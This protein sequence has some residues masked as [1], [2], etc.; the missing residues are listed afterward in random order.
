MKQNSDRLELNVD[1]IEQH[2]KSAVDALTPDVLGR[3]DLT[4]GQEP[5]MQRLDVK[6]HEPGTQRLDVKMHEP[7]AGADET[8]F[9]GQWTGGNHR[10]NRGWMRRFALAAAAC[11]CV[12]FVGG[13]MIQ[14][15]DRKV[16]SVIGIDVNPSVELSINRKHRVL[17]TRALNTD[18]VEIMTDMDLKGVELNVA[19]N[20][21]IGSMVTHGYLD[22]LDNAIL[23]TVS[24]DSVAKATE[25]R[26]SVVDDIER[27]LKENQVEAVV[28]DQQV[29]EKDE[30]K[31]LADRY[32]ISYGKAYFLKELIEQNEGLTMDDMKELSN[33]T[34]EEI[35]K[36]ITEDSFALGGLASKVER[37]G[38]TA[39]TKTAAPEAGS[40]AD[41]TEGA[42]TAGGETSEAVETSGA[43]GTVE[44]GDA[45]KTG[46]TSEAADTSKAADTSEAATPSESAETSAASESPN[47]ED[48]EG[49]PDEVE[50]GLVEIDYVDYEDDTVYVYFVTRVKWKN[51]TVSVRDEDG[52]SYAAKVEDTSSDECTIAVSG[53]EGGRS[54]AFVLGGLIPKES[55]K[56]T[57][58]TGYF[59]KPE[60]AWNADEPE[61]EEMEESED[62]REE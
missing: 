60:I 36:K 55:K 1:E 54:Y 11:I 20:A 40:E 62:D 17:G 56:A 42:E 23:V 39:E 57:T 7:G 22:E 51:P 24:N 15:R 47:Q 41:G 33:M 5:E 27:T 13:G 9:P 31:E 28:Y 46:E 32:G 49:F 44:A 2:L 8:D 10:Q 6:T 43:E 18:A 3:I 4:R 50:P 12:A 29:V 48:P 61:T 38:E 19:V 59:D 53:L 58:V 25:L 26:T 34:M 37:T 14:Y 45:L 52:N 21:V 16:D 30:M 35:A